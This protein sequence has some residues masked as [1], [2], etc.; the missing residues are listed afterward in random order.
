MDASDAAEIVALVRRFVREQVIPAENQ[1]EAEDEVPV[2]IREAALAMGLYGFAIPTEYGGLGMSQAQECELALELGYTTPA[3]RPLFGTNNGI[4][5]HVLIEGGT[6]QQ[7]KEWLPRLADGSVVASFALTEPEAGSDPSSLS[8]RAVRTEQGWSLSGAKRYITNAPI[9]DALFTFARV[10]SGPEEG[11]IATFIVP[12]STPGL[13]VAAPDQKMGQAGAYSA[14][15]HLDD[16]RIPADHL[17][18]ARTAC[19]A[20]SAPQCVAWC[21]AVSTSRSCASAR[22]NDCSTRWWP[23]RRGASKTGSW[24][25]G[26]N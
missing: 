24:L 5:G 7:R 2:G 17:V 4:A 9:V 10:E 18:G 15:V 26:T 21:A 22:P 14:D 3:F 13:T 11:N 8:T 16:V 23:S 20:G 6:E 19:G 25:P 1:I 12:V